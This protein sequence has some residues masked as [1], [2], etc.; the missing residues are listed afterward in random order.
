VAPGVVVERAS[1]GQ[2]RIVAVA[3]AAVAE[4]RVAWWLEGTTAS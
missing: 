2:R 3:E 1:V 4:M